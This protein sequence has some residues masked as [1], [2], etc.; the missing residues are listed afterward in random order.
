MIARGDG[1]R[2][3]DRPQFGSGRARLA[4]RAE[5]ARPRSSCVLQRSALH[6]ILLLQLPLGCALPGNGQDAGWLAPRGDLATGRAAVAGPV[7]PVVLWAAALERTPAPAPVA[8]A[9]KV[10]L[11]DGRHVHAHGLSDGREEWNVEC[12]SV[13]SG[14]SLG[15]E[16]LYVM[17][18]DGD[19]LVLS[20]DTGARV[21]SVRADV[22]PRPGVAAWPVA[23]KDGVVFV[24]GRISV[25]AL[26]RGSDRPLWTWSC[27]PAGDL[28]FLG[29]LT[30]TRDGA[31]LVPT[32]MGR[33]ISLD[34]GSGE[35][36]W[37]YKAPGFAAPFPA[38]VDG[39]TNRV[40]WVSPSSTPYR[41]AA[42]CIDADSG[43][44]LWRTLLPSLAC[45]GLALG[46][47]CVVAI[48]RDGMLNC[49]SPDDGHLLWQTA[50]PTARMPAAL[51]TPPI[52]DA[53]GRIY[54]AVGNAVLCYGREGDL[55]SALPLRGDYGIS[56]L[57][58]PKES[59]L[60]LV[61]PPNA[62]GLGQPQ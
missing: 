29:P 28:M 36:G 31:V 42:V 48:T 35:V 21:W 34:A 44:V 23:G 20:A 5:R 19:L 30:V 24:S 9:E 27:P 51:E 16:G 61:L 2:T 11:V 56:Y 40:Y 53:A 57:A 26:A 10:Y 25:Q 14:I 32:S 22:R 54:V 13:V 60:I 3:S 50:L 52:T 1:P 41:S 6:L 59:L 4:A 37:E 17:T 55:A 8:D 18:E 15:P 12:H 45:N 33:L 47:G 43:K 38:A 39:P 46:A 58:L 49:M 62:Y 7:E